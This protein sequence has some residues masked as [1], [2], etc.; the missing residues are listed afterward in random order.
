MEQVVSTLIL[1]GI[2]AGLVNFFANYVTLP[3][4]IGRSLLG[5]EP[6]KLKDIWYVAVPGYLIVGCAGAFLTP[7]INALAGTTGL[8][9]LENT[10]APMFKYI[11]FGYGLV[12]GYSTT[13]L[14]LSLLD[15]LLK[16]VATLDR[17]LTNLE[18]LALNNPDNKL[19]IIRSKA[20]DIIDECESLFEA[21]KNDC[22]GFVKAVSAAF[23][24]NLTGQ[25]NDIVSQIQGDRWTV[26]S[27]GVDAKTK[28]DAGWLV[29]AGLKGADN[30][31]SENNGHVVVIASGPL[32]QQKYPT[33][34][35]GKLNG[36]GEKNKTI[37]WAWNANSRDKVTYSA[38]KI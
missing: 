12:F 30:V 14:L 24:I 33:G 32:A 35:W 7:L 10:A 16:K 28:A 20:D 25:A 29:I 22:S 4:S 36:V 38:I 31:P 2:V 27:N 21:H 5:D 19:G 13:R 9:G 17:K 11:L 8:K 6:P 26:L 15:S 23:S 37:N 1:A 3:F 34:Y 18:K